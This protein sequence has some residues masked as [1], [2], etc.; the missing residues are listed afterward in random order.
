M[1]EDNSTTEQDDNEQGSP[2][3]SA[4]MY[5]YFGLGLLI[6]TASLVT[7]YTLW[8]C[9]KIT[10]QIRL[11]SLHM[12]VGNLIY[13]IALVCS[14]VYFIV[15][16]S[17]CTSI[18]KLLPVAFIIFNLFLTAAGVDRLLSLVYSLKYK[19]WH[20]KR[21]A[22]TLIVSIY[23]I[24]ICTNIPNVPVNLQFS[25]QIG[26]EMFTYKGLVSFSCSS[27]CLI[28]LD[29]LIYSCIGIIAIKTNL[30]T[31]N[32]VVLIGKEREST[33]VWLATGKCFALSIAT[34]VLLGP[35]IASR[36]IDFWYF[37]SIAMSQTSVI[38]SVFYLM[39][40]IFSPIFI[41]ASYKECRYQIAVLCCHFCKDKRDAIEKEYKQY[42]AT[43]VISHD[44]SSGVPNVQHH[45]QSNGPC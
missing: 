45:L 24:G 23:F 10:S 5:A 1:N 34:M 8:K 15:T 31:H 25:C 38:A 29:V 9:R 37:G 3:S 28:S 13:G 12:T 4:F 30:S 19:L 7:I 20:N 27:I 44:S 18:L 16:G 33:R 21:K 2:V 22:Y 39:H 17:V 26:T 40:Q 35:F 11:M 14:S 36:A 43:F 42:Y 41:L 6:V 32:R